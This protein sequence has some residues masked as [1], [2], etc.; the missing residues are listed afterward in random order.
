M[1]TNNL[2]YL[3]VKKSKMVDFIHVRQILDKILQFTNILYYL[4]Q[5]K[6][7]NIKCNQGHRVG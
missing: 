1:S 5:L 6:E 7:K 4:F 2:F 3:V